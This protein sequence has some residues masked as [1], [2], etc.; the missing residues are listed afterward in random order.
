MF[1]LVRGGFFHT[2]GADRDTDSEKTRS[3]YS[4]FH[5]GKYTYKNIEKHIQTY[6][7]HIKKHIQTYEK[8]ITTLET[9]IKHINTYKKH[10]KH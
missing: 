10:I 1:L 9:H 6:K 2:G 3:D 7:K 4:L 8:H 5:D